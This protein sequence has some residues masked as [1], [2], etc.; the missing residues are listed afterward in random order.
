MLERL[1]DDDA[2]LYSSEESDCEAG[3]ISRYML[4]ASNTLPNDKFNLS[5]DCSASD[6][7]IKPCPF[8]SS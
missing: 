4:E 7:V 1:G 5:L 3:G 2:G 6:I 8:T